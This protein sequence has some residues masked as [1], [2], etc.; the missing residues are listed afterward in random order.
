M[1][2]FFVFFALGPAAFFYSLAYFLKRPFEWQGPA[3]LLPISVLV[4]AFTQMAGF[5]WQ[6]RRSDQTGRT[7]VIVS[8]VGGIVMGVAVGLLTYFVL[9]E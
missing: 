9:L 1:E 5:K 3:I 7:V 8:Q 6:R 2:I 4:T